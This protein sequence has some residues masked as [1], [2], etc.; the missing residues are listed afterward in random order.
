MFS[1]IYLCYKTNTFKYE[2]KKFNNYEEADKYFT[3]TFRYR[4]I[5]G[6]NIESTMFPVCKF[7]PEFMKNIVIHNKLSNRIILLDIKN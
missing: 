6:Q 2:C 1:D 4:N 3:E 7:M 5:T